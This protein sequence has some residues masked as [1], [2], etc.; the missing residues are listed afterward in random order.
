M[1]V[2]FILIESGIQNHAILQM[3]WSIPSLP[4][5]ILFVWFQRSFLNPSAHLLNV[6][7]GEVYFGF[8]KIG[9]I[10]KHYQNFRGSRC[11]C[12]A[13]SH[14]S[15]S[16]GLVQASWQ[17]APDHKRVSIKTN[18]FVTL[19]CYYWLVTVTIPF[20]DSIISEVVN[21]FADDKRA[22]FELCALTP[23]IKGKDVQETAGTLKSQWK[24]LLPLED[25][26]DSEL[27][28][29]KVH[30]NEIPKEKSV[31]QLLCEDADPNCKLLCYL[32]STSG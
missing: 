13:W 18:P 4:L 9:K 1:T 32:G 5:S 8:K 16:I 23:E 10:T 26:L 19:P 6:C 15:W 3:D 29:W 2:K 24:H 27:S 25:N 28:Q 17:N 14:L 31:T 11:R 12:W 22:H 21:R 30:Y 20:L 7:K